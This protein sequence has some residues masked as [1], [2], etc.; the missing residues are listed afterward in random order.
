M[1]PVSGVSSVML[2]QVTI[3]AGV[4]EYYD[5]ERYVPPSQVVSSLKVELQFEVGSEPPSHKV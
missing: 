5:S 3:E 4:R 2:Q 1:R